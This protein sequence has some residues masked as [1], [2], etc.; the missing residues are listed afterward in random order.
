MFFGAFLGPI[1]AIILMNFIIFIWITVIV[2]RSTKAKLK[3]TNK[4]L[5]PKK[6]IRLMIS[7]IGIMFTFGITWVSSALTVQF[8]NNIVVR[9]IFQAM[10]V[11]FGAF[12]GFFIFLF[13]CMLD[14][15]ARHAWKYLF[16]HKPKSDYTSSSLVNTLRQ[17]NN[18][19][20]KSLPFDK[21]VHLSYV[22]ELK[23]K[24]RGKEETIGT[25]TFCEEKEE[26][27]DMEHIEEPAQNESVNTEQPGLIKLDE[28]KD[29]QY[30]L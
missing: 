11:I 5:S 12:Q 21:K 27:I 26:S 6:A 15:K 16:F 29:Y 30:Y 25:T 14:K 2:L 7:L 22:P 19:S 1:L 4:K 23:E 28:K 9:D 8:G 3:R 24:I 13:F 18:H 10:F 20:S 17:G